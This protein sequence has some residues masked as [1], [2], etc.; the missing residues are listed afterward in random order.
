[1]KKAFMTPAEYKKSD[2]ETKYYY[3]PEYK[4][5]RNKKE[6][7]YSDCNCCGSRQFL[8]WVER[9]IPVGE[10]YRYKKQDRVF[11]YKTV[12]MMDRIAESDLK[13]LTTYHYPKPKNFGDRITIPRMGKK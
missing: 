12:L 3:S 13:N 10:P 8:G 11:S 1:M 7:D 2:K 6:R 4:K 5:Y 9:T